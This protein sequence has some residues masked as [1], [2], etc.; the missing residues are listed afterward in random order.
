MGF[1]KK[2]VALIKVFLTM[3]VTQAIVSL[4]KVKKL[5]IGRWILGMRIASLLKVWYGELDEGDMYSRALQYVKTTECTDEG[6]R[7]DIG[8]TLPGWYIGKRG[9]L[10]I[11]TA[12]YLGSEFVTRVNIN[13]V[14]CEGDSK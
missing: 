7:I 2:K 9:S 6:I 12:S 11:K 4:A 8:T 3:K 14:P 5:R 13:I 1:I 10:V